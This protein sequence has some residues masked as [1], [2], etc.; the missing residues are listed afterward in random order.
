M[1]EKKTRSSPGAFLHYTLVGI[2]RLLWLRATGRQVAVTGE[3]LQCG[4]CCREINLYKKNRWIRSESE[5]T[6]LT[7]ARTE[8]A[9]FRHTGYTLTGLMKFACEHVNEAGLCGDYENRPDFCRSYPETCLY[10]MGG[11]LKEHCGYRFEVAPSFGRMLRRELKRGPD[12][13]TP[14]QPGG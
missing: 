7:A 8:F 9:R 4:R 11:E 3:C 12:G 5:F 10:F 2:L 13:K 6:R 14:H 1:S